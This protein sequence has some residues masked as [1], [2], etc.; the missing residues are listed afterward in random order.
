MN[1]LAIK[2]TLALAAFALAFA[3]TRQAHAVPFIYNTGE[4]AFVAGDGSIPSPF[5][6]LVEQNPESKGAKAGYRCNV[7]GLFYAY[8]HWWDCKPIIF[9]ETGSKT[10]TYWD[11]SALPGLTA[12]VEKAHPQ[13]DIKLGFWQKFG[14]FV[15]GGVLLALI[16]FG[17]MRLVKKKAPA[18]PPAPGAAG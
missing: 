3:A 11:D 2:L 10:F 15:I 6:E 7:F 18:T 5:G 1:R 14:R 8:F 16:V 4:D 12:A 17:I 13:S 9:K